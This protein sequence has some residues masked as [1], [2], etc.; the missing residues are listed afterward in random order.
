[1]NYKK[2][3]QNATDAMIFFDSVGKILEINSSMEDVTGYK[4][5]NVIGNHIKQFLDDYSREELEDLKKDPSQRREI[6]IITK[7]GEKKEMDTKINKFGEDLYFAI[8]RDVTKHKEL[9]E[10]DPLTEICNY[11]KFYDSLKEEMEKSRRYDH[12][13]S[14]LLIDVDN[15]KEYNDTKGH[16]EGDKLLK[17][18][19]E[20]LKEESRAAD[21]VC[22]YGGDEFSIILPET[23]KEGAK[24]LVRRIKES[25]ERVNKGITGLSIGISEFTNEEDPEEIVEKADKK[26]YVEKKGKKTRSD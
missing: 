17:K 18:I 15:F 16:V 3:F 10:K 2:I 5:D 4:K 20:L 26:M 1:M 14:I 21:V 23:D 25:Y 22:R 7:N 6:M 11:R 19:A 13:L 9:A 12:E 8:L 24:K